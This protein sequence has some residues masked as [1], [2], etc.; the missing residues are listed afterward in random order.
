MLIKLK[1]KSSI[2][3]V[4]WIKQWPN[5]LMQLL[6]V[7]L[8]TYADTIFPLWNPTGTLEHV[9][10]DWHVDRVWVL[11]RQTAAGSESDVRLP[12]L[13]MNWIFGANNL[14]TDQ[15]T[16]ALSGNDPKKNELLLKFISDFDSFDFKYDLIN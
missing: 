7:P 1:L 4:Y 15:I 16:R 6:C 14:L 5:V 12:I 10:W 3:S 13:V 8:I 2:F 11:I 9:C